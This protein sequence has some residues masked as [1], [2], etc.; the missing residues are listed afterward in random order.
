MCKVKWPNGKNGQMC[1]Y[2]CVQIYKR[3]R[4]VSPPGGFAEALPSLANSHSPISIQQLFLHL[5]SYFVQLLVWS[6]VTTLFSS[7]LHCWSNISVSWYSNFLS[8]FSLWFTYSLLLT[9]LLINFQWLLLCCQT[10]THFT[11]FCTITLSFVR[12]VV[13]MCLWSPPCWFECVSNP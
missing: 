4:I 11:T 2:T 8:L 13:D 1:K 12:I 7:I 5:Y 6:L 9:F 3:R 10:A